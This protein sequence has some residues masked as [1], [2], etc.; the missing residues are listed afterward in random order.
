MWGKWAKTMC[1][2]VKSVCLGTYAIRES[3]TTTISSGGTR[4]RCEDHSCMIWCLWIENGGGVSYSLLG[5]MKEMLSIK[6][7]YRYL[8]VQVSSSPN[9]FPFQPCWRQI[10]HSLTPNR[11][12]YSTHTRKLLHCPVSSTDRKCLLQI[13]IWSPLCCDQI[14]S[15]Q[16]KDKLT[17]FIWV[18]LHSGSNAIHIICVPWDVI[19][20]CDNL[21]NITKLA[22]IKCIFFI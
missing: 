2:Y 18:K 15:R 10:T 5:T 14:S 11:L 4:L 20:A 12:A 13:Y 7:F 22:G 9:W 16:G 8:C 6:L 3:K 1:C 17:E 19:L 21:F